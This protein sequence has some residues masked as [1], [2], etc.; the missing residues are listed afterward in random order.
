MGYYYRSGRASVSVK[1]PNAFAVCDR[2]GFLYNHKDL[3]WQDQWI[4]PRLQNLRILVCAECRD[5]PQDQ[6]RTRIIPADPIPIDV[7]RQESYITEISTLPS[8]IIPGPDGDIPP[9]TDN[10]A[11]TPV[12][13]N[14][15]DP[16]P[17]LAGPT[18]PSSYFSVP[19]V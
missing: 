4:G 5:K 14:Q 2:C 10:P 19:P 8:G 9:Q 17:G 15:T 1:R 13:P 16:V 18:Q 12:P 11:P 7:P 3:I 6:L